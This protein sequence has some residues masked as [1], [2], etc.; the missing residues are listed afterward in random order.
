MITLPF[1]GLAWE[2][3]R[4]ARNTL[5]V[6]L[7]AALLIYGVYLTRSRGG[8]LGVLAVAL[9][10]MIGRMGRTRAIVLTALLAV[11]LIGLNF[12]GGRGM[13]NDDSA[14][15]RVDAWSEGLQ[16]FRESPL[17][18]VGLHNFSEHN[19]L[20]AH[21]SFVLCFA[22]LGITGYFF[23]MAL[24][25]GAFRQLRAVRK[26]ADS[27]LNPDLRDYAR[28]CEIAF[29]GFL[30]SAFFLSRDRKSVV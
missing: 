4:T 28:A 1:L 11:M 26:S 19:Y 21:N 27:D 17:L 18:G 13:T 24:L 3:R 22:E 7:P 14:Q 23:W 16:M 20:T 15:G 8:L 2:R 12:T 10:A 9:A 6:V 25:V 5:L 30:A 29:I